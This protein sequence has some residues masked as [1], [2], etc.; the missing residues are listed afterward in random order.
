MLLN[1]EQYH[2]KPWFQLDNFKTRDSQLYI[3][4]LAEPLERAVADQAKKEE[5]KNRGK[6]RRK[7]VVSHR[8]RKSEQQF[9]QREEMSTGQAGGRSVVKVMPRISDEEDRQESLRTIR[10][11]RRN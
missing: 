3:H 10:M 6:G 2:T 9:Q 5:E 8:I 7:T 4:P 1:A 11:Y